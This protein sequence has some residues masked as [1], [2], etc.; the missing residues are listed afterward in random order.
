[1]QEGAF[2]GYTASTSQ[3][4]VLTRD[5]RLIKVTN[6]IFCDDT[7]GFIAEQ[8]VS[9]NLDVFGDEGDEDE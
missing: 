1:M 4:I 5:L 2:V 3:Y 7:P 6:P 9:L 8:Q